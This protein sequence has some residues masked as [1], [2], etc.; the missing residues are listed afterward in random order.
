MRCS[1]GRLKV[2][3]ETRCRSWNCSLWWKR[4]KSWHTKLFLSLLTSN[5]LWLQKYHRNGVSSLFFLWAFLRFFSYITL[6]QIIQFSWHLN[7]S[8]TPSFGPSWFSHFQ[9]SELIT[10][11]NFIVQHTQKANVKFITNSV[12]LHC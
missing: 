3:N 12:V 4:G 10:S 5:R 2:F 7:V 9:C 11:E 1:I 6:R 8:L